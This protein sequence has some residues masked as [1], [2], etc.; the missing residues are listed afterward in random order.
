MNGR[1][2]QRQRLIEDQVE[3]DWQAKLEAEGAEMNVF[4][5]EDPEF[6]DCL[7]YF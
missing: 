7:L 3:E 1:E 2:R 5:E 6:T 4:V